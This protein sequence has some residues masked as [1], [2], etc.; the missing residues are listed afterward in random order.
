MNYYLQTI[1]YF[2]YVMELGSNKVGLLEKQRKFGLKYS[3]E[4]KNW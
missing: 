1:R 3:S 4:K 2:H